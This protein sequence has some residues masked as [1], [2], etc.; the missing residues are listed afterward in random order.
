MTVGQKLSMA[1]IFFPTRCPTNPAVAVIP[2][3]WHSFQ[4]LKF[5]IAKI[6]GPF[7]DKFFINLY[8]DVREISEKRLNIPKH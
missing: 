5:I 4:P 2:L 1:V 3:H 6:K 8:A 7:K